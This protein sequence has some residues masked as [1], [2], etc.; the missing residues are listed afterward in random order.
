MAPWPLL[1]QLA[2]PGGKQRLSVYLWLHRYGHGRED[3]CW[4]SVQTL[5]SKCG[6][7]AKSVK[8]ALRWLLE[9]GW[10]ERVSRPGRT[11]FYFVRADAPQ[12]K[13][14]R[15]TDPGGET[16]PGG[17]TDPGVKTTLGTW[18]AKPPHDPEQTSKK[19]LIQEQPK[20]NPPVSPQPKQ[21][22]LAIDSPTLTLVTDPP[23]VCDTPLA[24]AGSKPKAVA[25]PIPDEFSHLAEHIAVW[26]QR[27]KELGHKL[28][29]W[30]PGS[31]T[32]AALRLAI[33]NG[34]AVAYLEAAADAGWQ[35][36]GHA[37][38]KDLIGRLA[39][40]PAPAS[41]PSRF[42]FQHPEPLPL[43]RY[44]IGAD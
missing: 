13:V 10:V 2:E 44:V 12:P 37:G 34:V 41:G 1:D 39:A 8:G 14:G 40:P 36:L 38:H 15:E 29:P 16:S 25:D 9:T 22:R 18:G 5:A 19:E 35:S 26:L 17:G 42:R 11:S 24:K 27:R 28:S 23:K 32:P 21:G 20:E 7:D 31:R 43:P 6:M 4:A 3:G 30:S 33:A